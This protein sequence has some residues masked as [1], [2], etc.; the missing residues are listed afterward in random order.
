MLRPYTLQ[1]DCD[2]SNS[3]KTCFHEDSNRGTRA[4]HDLRPFSHVYYLKITILLGE[5]IF[6][7]LLQSL[8]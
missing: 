4:Q 5:N 8:E 3:F 2:L 6:I 7:N 1:E